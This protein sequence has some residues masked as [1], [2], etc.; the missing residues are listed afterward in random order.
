MEVELENDCFVPNLPD[1][2][3]LEEEEHRARL[4]WLK[5]MTYDLKLLKVKK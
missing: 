3:L 5:N 2:D 4:V 1:V